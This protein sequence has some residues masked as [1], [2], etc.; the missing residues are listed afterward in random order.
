[1]KGR[2]C[3]CPNPATFY[4]IKGL[5]PSVDSRKQVLPILSWFVH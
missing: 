4:K 5:L 3:V 2:E 1:M